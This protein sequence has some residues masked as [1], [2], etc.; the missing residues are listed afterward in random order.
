MTERFDFIPV[1]EEG[2][3]GFE[4]DPK[5]VV[6][7]RKTPMVWNGRVYYLEKRREIQVPKR[8]LPIVFNEGIFLQKS[9]SLQNRYDV[10]AFTE[11]GRSVSIPA[12]S[13]LVIEGPIKV[14]V[15][16]RI[17]FP[18]V[19]D[20]STPRAEQISAEEWESCQPI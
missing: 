9:F 7:L 8:N 12:G 3:L 1:V 15:A 20:Y 2:L 18:E 4:F 16:K 11:G 13:T 6:L 5:I 17:I 10:P 19:I 14:G